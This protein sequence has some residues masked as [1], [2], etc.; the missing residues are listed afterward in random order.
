MAGEILRTKRF[1]DWANII[2]H[3]RS[4][5]V[6]PVDGPSGTAKMSKDN[7]L[8]ETGLSGAF[9]YDTSIYSDWNDL[10][11]G[12]SILISAHLANEPSGVSSPCIGVTIGS[13]GADNFAF[14]FCYDITA[15]N[16]LYFRKMQSNSWK[17]WNKVV[18]ENFLDGKLSFLTANL[19]GNVSNA[20]VTPSTWTTG[21][22]TPSGSTSSLAG[23]YTI[24][25]TNPDDIICICGYVHYNTSCIVALESNSFQSGTKLRQTSVTGNN[26]VYAKATSAYT[27][28]CFWNVD[29]N[30]RIYK[31]NAGLFSETIKLLMN[32]PSVQNDTTET[33]NKTKFLVDNLE[34]AGN[35][36]VTPSTFT[37]GYW[38][39]S[40]GN[41][42]SNDAARATIVPTDVGD[43]IA[44]Y[45][46]CHSNTAPV[47][48]LT[49]NSFVGGAVLATV[50]SSGENILLVKATSAYT[51]VCFWGSPIDSEIKIYKLKAG[52]FKQVKENAD[53]IDE[54]NSK[55][56]NLQPPKTFYVGYGVADGVTHFDKVWDAMEATTAETGWVNI[57]I[58]SGTYDLYTEMGGADYLSTI[59]DTSWRNWVPV[60]HKV[61]MRGHG[62]VKITY[63]PPAEVAALYPNANNVISILNVGG[64]C[65]IENLTLEGQYCRYIIHDQVASQVAEER[66]ST[67]VYKNLRCKMIKTSAYGQVV[68]GGFDLHQVIK[69]IDCYFEGC[70]TQSTWSYHQG[71]RAT[72]VIDNCVFIDNSNR[73]Y[74]VRFGN[75]PGTTS[76]YR[77]PVRFSNCYFSKAIRLNREWGDIQSVNNFDITITNSNSVNVAIAEEI[78]DIVYTPKIYNIIS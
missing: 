12:K 3:F 29:S 16:Q 30:T 55:L 74:C 4:G 1:N 11:I 22:W 6:I 49:E 35:E 76:T 46:Y 77:C 13:W 71:E 40:T 41:W 26:C 53:S 51:G 48:A 57:E 10:P 62:D 54:I 28:V 23:N 8:K 69:Y 63:M 42:V 14:Q 52:L 5:D 15:N 67:K 32:F 31:L 61:R 18:S 33:K 59:T 44:I 65:E 45:G 72:F 24:I 39:K 20:D 73:D 68:G 43:V 58:Y 78:S 17:A 25:P 34:T 19:E 37:K 21:Y 56:L 36:N 60:L 75:K 9:I 64:D 27:G 70:P 7:L 66:I 38:N 50:A 2:S 47:V